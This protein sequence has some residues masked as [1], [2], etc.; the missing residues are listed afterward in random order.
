M[1]TFG[2]E[3][4]CAILYYKRVCLANSE[5][6]IVFLV[7][8]ILQD[9]FVPHSCGKAQLIL[10]FILWGMRI[11]WWSGPFLIDLG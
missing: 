9:C 6:I 8:S 7:Q 10:I 1:T 11:V 2:T 4:S 3:Q 5:F